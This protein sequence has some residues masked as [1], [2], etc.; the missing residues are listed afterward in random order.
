MSAGAWWALATP[1]FG[2]VWVVLGCTLLGQGLER[3]LNPRLLVN[4]LGGGDAMIDP[5][6]RRQKLAKSP[7]QVQP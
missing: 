6:L 3:A 5:A 2:I 1:G 4:H 7:A